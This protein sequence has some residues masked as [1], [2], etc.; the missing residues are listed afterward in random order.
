[1]VLDYLH[2]PFTYANL[3]NLLRT[4]PFGTVFGNLRRLDSWRLYWAITEGDRDWLRHHLESGLPCI[5][6][7]RTGAPTWHEETN[8]AVLITGIGDEAGDATLLYFHDP[9]QSNG[10]QQVL[11]REFA[12]YWVEQ[13]Y[14][15]AVI[16]LDEP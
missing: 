11:Y 9:L 5:A 14:L 13:E 2:V 15:C 1:M 6:A 10:P 16:A 4:Q 3:L 7:I 12:V 8:H